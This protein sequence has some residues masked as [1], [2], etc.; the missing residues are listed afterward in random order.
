M[1]T[2]TGWGRSTN[3]QRINAE[4]FARFNVATT[5]L[6]KLDLP[7]LSKGEC[8][9]VDVYRQILQLNFDLQFCAG[10]E[11]GMNELKYFSM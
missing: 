8:L 9:K 10:G 7:L 2:V 3:D 11:K 1:L 5:H 6:Q 4:N